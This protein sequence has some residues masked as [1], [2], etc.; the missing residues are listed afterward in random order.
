MKAAT[1]KSNKGV[2]KSNKGVRATHYTFC[3]FDGFVRCVALTL[4]VSIFGRFL[5][6]TYGS[7]VSADVS[8]KLA[9]EIVFYQSAMNPITK[10]ACGKL[11]KGA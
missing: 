3:H 6:A 7:S 8:D 9:I 2:R 1:T 4:K 10:I 5:P 11:G